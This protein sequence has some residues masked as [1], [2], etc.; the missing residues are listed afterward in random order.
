MERTAPPPRRQF[1]IRGPRHIARLIEGRRREGTDPL[2][3]TLAAGDQRV[4]HF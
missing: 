4:G 2:R 1:R 3:Q